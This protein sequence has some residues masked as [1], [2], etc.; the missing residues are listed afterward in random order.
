M[1]IKLDAVIERIREVVRREPGIQQSKL[2][3]LVRERMEVAKPMLSWAINDL[4]AEGELLKLGRRGLGRNVYYCLAT[5]FA[6]LD[7][8]KF[9]IVEAASAERGSISQIKR[10]FRDAAGAELPTNFQRYPSTIAQFVGWM[11]Q[12]AR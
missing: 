7:A 10:V 9:F 1:S 5:D 2:Q 4:R 6:K 12:E 8:S 11:T 3:V